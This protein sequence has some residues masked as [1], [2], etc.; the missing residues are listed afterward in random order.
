MMSVRSEREILGC[1]CRTLNLHPQ[2]REDF[3]EVV[4]LPSNTLRERGHPLL[5]RAMYGRHPRCKGKESDF[6]A[7]RSGA[8]MYTACSR[9][10]VSLDRD[11]AAV[12]AGPDVIR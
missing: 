11:A 12:A 5:G 2:G 8:A 7:K 10:E 6:F 4:R 3:R 9:L 1:Y